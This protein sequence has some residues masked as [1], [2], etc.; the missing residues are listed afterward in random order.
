MRNARDLVS[1]SVAVFGVIAVGSPR[2]EAQQFIGPLP[3]LC[4]TDSPLYGL[5]T[6]LFLA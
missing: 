4:E 1:W 5:V 3:Y 2:A 6:R